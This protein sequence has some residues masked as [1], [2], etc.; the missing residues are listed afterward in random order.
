MKTIRFDL[1]GFINSYK[2]PFFRTY[3][4]SLLAPPKSTIIGMLCNISLKSQK[5]FFDILNNDN[6]LVSVVINSIDGYAKDLWS[7]KTLKKDDTRGKSVI[8]R[9]KLF[10][11]YYTVYLKL[12]NSLYEEIINSL[13]SPKNIP[14]LGMDDE[15]I[16]ITNIFG[17]SEFKLTKNKTN[18]ID[19]IFL[20]KDYNY[21][22]K[23]KDSS[24]SI[25]LPTFH[26]IATKFKA[27]DSN[28][29]FIS[30]EPIKEA[31]YNQ[32]EFVN[33]EIEFNQEIDSYI[34]DLGNRIVFY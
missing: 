18:C 30:R 33:C 28:G 5:K 27:F 14:S 3:H 34:D 15:I 32:V 25:I 22:V 17:D 9:D 6:I 13:K 7:Y 11:A 2:V 29:K 20:D 16:N 26:E 1:N 19:S 8:Q 21:K 24:K 4:K 23:V 10:N 31:I 12:D